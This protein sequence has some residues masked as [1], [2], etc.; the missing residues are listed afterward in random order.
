MKTKIKSVTVIT[1]QGT[2]SYHVGETYNNLLL[3][4]I[5]DKS[6]EYPDSIMIIYGGLTADGFL[7]FE[8]INVPVNVEYCAAE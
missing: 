5:E 2:H 8:V 1:L 7:V 3:D 4:R 6:I